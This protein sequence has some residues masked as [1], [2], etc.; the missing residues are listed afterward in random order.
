MSIYY[1]RAHLAI[2]NPE[3]REDLLRKL[4]EWKIRVLAKIPEKANP[5]YMT[6]AN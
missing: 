4:K 6:M 2:S 3:K 5:E 1:E